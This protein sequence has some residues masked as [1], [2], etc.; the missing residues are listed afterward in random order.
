[1]KRKEP[2]NKFLNFQFQ[3]SV[4]TSEFKYQNINAQ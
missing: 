4:K 1:M 3:T 2:T